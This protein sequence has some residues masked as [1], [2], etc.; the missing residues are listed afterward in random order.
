MNFNIKAEEAC[1]KFWIDADIS[2]PTPEMKLLFLSGYSQ[3][4]LDVTAVLN[5]F[6]SSDTED[7]CVLVDSDGESLEES[8]KE[9][10]MAW[11]KERIEQMEARDKE[12]LEGTITTPH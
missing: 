5:D 10:D 9:Q 4:T 7:D 2:D 6:L 11:M 8:T 1:T 3:A 12:S